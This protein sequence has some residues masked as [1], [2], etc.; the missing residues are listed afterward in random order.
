MKKKIFTSIFMV[1]IAFV[2]F[3]QSFSCTQVYHPK[4]DAPVWYL[5]DQSNPTWGPTNVTNYG[6]TEYLDTQVWTWNG[7]PGKKRSY[8]AI[9][10]LFLNNLTT[11]YVD[12]CYLNLFNPFD[13]EAFSHRYSEGRSNVTRIYK[14]TEEWHESNVTWNNKPDYEDDE[15]TEIGIIPNQP[16]IQSHDDIFNIDITPVVLD[17]DHQLEDNYYGIVLKQWTEDLTTYYHKMN[18]ASKNHPNPDYWPQLCI[19]Y[20]FPQPG[21]FYNGQSLTV[22]GIDDIEMLFYNHVTYYWDI[23]GVNYF[24]KTIAYETDNIEDVQLTLTLKITN[25]IGDFCEY[26]FSLIPTMVNNVEYKTVA[27]V[28]NPASSSF[29]LSGIDVIERISIYDAL[30][31]E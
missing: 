11:T 24:G 4:E 31:K 30:G 1:F 14:V 12:S 23:D 26:S 2:C 29:T 8:I 5:E 28:P 3:S 16:N 9:D 21:V 15:Y 7:S 17:A 6:T 18:F 25:N 22:T 19:K 13:N 20:I 27:I 10:L